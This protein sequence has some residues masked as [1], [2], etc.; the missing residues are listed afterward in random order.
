MYLQL[1][2]SYLSK[3]DFIIISA[4]TIDIKFGYFED[5]EETVDWNR[6]KNMLSL[7]GS[8]FAFIIPGAQ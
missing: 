6:V 5:L 1:F 8:S 3:L 4:F 2:S 7:L